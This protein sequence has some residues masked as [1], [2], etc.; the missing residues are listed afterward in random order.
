MGFIWGSYG[1]CG[2]CRIWGVCGVRC[3]DVLAGEWGLWVGPCRD[4]DTLG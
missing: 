2:V 1:V 4:S 3:R